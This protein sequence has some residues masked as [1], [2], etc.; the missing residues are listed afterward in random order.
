[1]TLPCTP[2]H[3]HNLILRQ[4][5]TLKSNQAQDQ[6][7]IILKHAHN[8]QN[9]KKTKQEKKGYEKHASHAHFTHLE[10]VLGTARLALAFASM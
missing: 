6:R 10:I 9:A 8:F 2:P 7:L 4:S 3:S 5:Y 1:M